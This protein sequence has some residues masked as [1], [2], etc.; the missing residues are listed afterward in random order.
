MEQ[1]LARQVA[2][3]IDPQKV[4][5]GFWPAYFVFLRRESEDFPAHYVVVCF[6]GVPVEGSAEFDEGVF[7]LGV[8]DVADLEVFAP[9]IT[10]SDV[11]PEFREH[12]ESAGRAVEP[13]FQ[14][15]VDT[16]LGG[17][18]PAVPFR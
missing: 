15:Y 13:R 2:L 12:V 1:G 18:R 17:R 6:F 9:V 4:P 16:Y 8:T 5:S 3:P 11:P 7:A 10:L 14:T